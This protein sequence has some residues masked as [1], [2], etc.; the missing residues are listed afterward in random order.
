MGAAVTLA[1]AGKESKW[2]RDPGEQGSLPGDV[3]PGSSSSP[4]SSSAASACALPA[5]RG[6]EVKDGRCRGCA[7]V[8]GARGER[9]HSLGCDKLRS[10]GASWHYRVSGGVEMLIPILEECV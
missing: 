4:R 9:A 8:G 10:G 3:T 1:R 5:C 6:L 2:R 7:R